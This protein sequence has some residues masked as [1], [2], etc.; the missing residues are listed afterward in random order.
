M[1]ELA[2]MDGGIT[3]YIY[4]YR[5]SGDSIRCVK[6]TPYLQ[7]VTSADLNELMPN[8]GDTATLI[9]KRDEEEYVVGKL[10]DGKY[11]ML[12]NLRLDPTTVD[13]TKLQTLSN[14]SATTI[15]Y[16]KNGGGSSP[17]PAT[18][19]NTTWASSSDD[20][21]NEPKVVTTYK[22]TA[23]T[24][25]G[26]GSGK[27]SVYYNYCVASAGSY[28]FP[29][30]DGTGDA[31]EDLCPAGWRMPTDGYSGGEYPALYAAYN[32]DAT[33]LRNAL[34]TPLSGYFKSGSARYQGEECYFWSSAR[35]GGADMFNLKFDSSSVRPT[36]FISRF[37]GDSLRCVLDNQ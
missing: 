24:S 3:P 35:V 17:Y 6:K 28:C 22:D 10:A 9:D 7:D 26:A 23:A 8:T 2:D 1:H 36:Y 34:S 14:A 4:N 21:Y 18:G 29:S 30:S 11:W 20:K 19:V 5:Y 33:S 13:L 15:A 32:S 16:L 12:D 31:T 37:V 25:Y 27:I